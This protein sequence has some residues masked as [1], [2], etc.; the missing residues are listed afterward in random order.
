MRKRRRVFCVGS[1]ERGE[2]FGSLV[3]DPL[4]CKAFGGWLGA[5]K[6]ADML[7]GGAG[8]KGEGGIGLRGWHGLHK[9]P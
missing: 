8:D 6:I 4:R 2:K 7:V 1:R 5:T 9:T 3:S